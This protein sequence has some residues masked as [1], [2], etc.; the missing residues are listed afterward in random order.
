MITKINMVI[1]MEHDLDAAV[2]FY[3]QLG[4][5]LIFRLKDKWAEFELGGVKIGL[6]P[7]STAQSDFTTGLVLQVDDL[8]AVYEQLKSSMNFLNE[9]MAKAH[10][11]MVSIKDPGNNIIDLYQPTPEILQE[12]MKKNAQKENNKGCCGSKND[13]DTC[14]TADC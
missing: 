4:L 8:Y 9:P 12:L 2:A 6:C 1:L 3:Q 7:T 10:G 11:I 14:D 13:S 5:R